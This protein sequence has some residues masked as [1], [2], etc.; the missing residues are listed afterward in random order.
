MG[1]VYRATDTRLKRQVAIKILPPAF[2]A[3]ADRLAR[4]QREAE[5]L[6][7]LNHPNIAGIY[8]L[9]ETN[10][11]A[12][13]VME[14]VDGEDLSQKIDGVK[15]RGSGLPIDEALAIA[16]QIADALEAA[17]GQ[18]II[19]RDLKPANVKVR[20]DGTVKVLDFGLAKAMDRGSGTGDHRSGGAGSLSMSPTFATPLV[21][22]AG[23]IVG[24]AAYMSPEQ[25][26]GRDTDARSDVWAFGCLVYEMLSGHR[27]FEADDVPGTMAAILERQPTWDRLPAATP[28]PMRRLLRRCLEKDP[29]RRLH[30]IADARLE[31]DDAIAGPAADAPG[32]VSKGRWSPLARAAIVVAALAGAALAWSLKPAGGAGANAGGGPARFL[33]ALS[34]PMSETDGLLIISR[35]GRRVAYA[36]GPA[37]RQQLFVREVDQFAS[38][39]VPDTDG[40]VSAAFSPDGQAIGFVAE[41]K[42]RTVSLSGGTPLTLRDRVDGAGLTWTT[43][44]FIFYNPGT[45]TGIWR[46]PAAG[47]EAVAVTQPGVKDNEQRFPELLP[48]GN[49]LLFSARGG[50]TDD[51]VYVESLKTHE[52]HA[53]AKG[54]GPHYLASGHLVFVQAGT[55]FAVR[56]DA[57]RL[58]VKGTPVAIIEGIRQARSGQPLI[59]YSE[60]GSIVYVPT[61]VEPGSNAL[62][63]VDRSGAEQP[64]GAAGRP[65][66]QPRLSPDGRRVVTSLRG[67]TEDL[68]MIDLTRG[69]SSRLTAESNTSFPVWTPDGRRLT[70]ASAKEGSYSIYWRPA[71]GS[72]PDERLLSGSWP[73]YPFSWSA[74]G[75]TLAFVSV[76]PTTLQDIRVLNVERPGT[77]APFVETQF[78]EGG[79][80]FS[81]DGKW[82]A[83]V[84]DESGRFE[85]YVRPF[86][87]PGEKWSISVEG[88]NEPVWPRGG[89]Q[90]FY[91]AGDAMMAVDVETSPTFSAGKPRRLFDTPYERS[92][93]LWANFDA[94]ADGQRLLMIKRGNPSAAASHVNVVLNWAEELAARVP[95]K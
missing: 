48:N 53:L 61:S 1:Q 57:E 17:H 69:S 62:V 80:V 89:K 50:V 72:A 12:A 7:S 76:S 45:A 21:T 91:R 56:F 3:D 23:M 63:W 51:Q 84:S 33:I 43:D 34:Q 64:T 40:V 13:L 52:R 24:T 67:N 10:G 79:P 31:I 36:A 35:D 66:A 6:A 70:L 16:R 4:F 68:W 29:K 74:D 2:A 30:D 28:P 20:A 65:Y 58:E 9:E 38:R 55:L 60:T 25:A 90:L 73:N 81:P 8:G 93:A 49:A 54:S 82:I 18:G 19:H 85:I 94:S 26:K 77:S 39:A 95:A 78:R 44:Q 37:D 88:G 27:P 14:L 42:L 86:P 32:I 92:I 15:A 11:A 46:I 59:S 41:R 75:K 22:Q 71:D 83:Y 5:V 47:G 87:G